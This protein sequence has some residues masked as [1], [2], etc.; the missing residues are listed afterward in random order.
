MAARS[1][2]HHQGTRRTAARR[3]RFRHA[4]TPD[5]GG[6]ATLAF[7]VEDLIAFFDDDERDED[8]LEAPAPDPAGCAEQRRAG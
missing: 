8:R 1:R 3:R 4:L 2:R 5:G 6:A 7:D